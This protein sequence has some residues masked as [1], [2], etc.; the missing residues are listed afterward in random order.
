MS[1]IMHN[2]DGESSVNLKSESIHETTFHLVG[3]KNMKSARSNCC[4][5]LKKTHLKL[6]NFFLQIGSAQSS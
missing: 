4:T 3:E 1:K 6:Q 2:T 5:I